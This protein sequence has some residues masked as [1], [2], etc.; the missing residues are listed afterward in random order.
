MHD[1]HYF[2]EGCNTICIDLWRNHEGGGGKYLQSI[3]FG[4]ALGGIIGPVIAKPF[5][6]I[7]QRPEISNLSIPY[8]SPA[9]SQKIDE[10]EVSIFHLFP[11]LG[12]FS[13]L[14]SIGYLVY[15]IMERNECKESINKIDNTIHN[16]CVCNLNKTMQKTSMR[17]TLSLP[18]NRGKQ[19]EKEQTVKRHSIRSWIFLGIMLT[20]FICYVGIEAS[21]SS[22]LSAFS[23]NSKLQLSQQEGTI[24]TSYFWV[25]FATTRLL[26][27]FVP[28]RVSSLQ[29]ICL[30]LSIINFGC[31][32]LCIYSDTSK[33]CLSVFSA[34]VGSALGP[35]FGNFIMWLEKHLL[36]DVNVNA[37][38]TIFGSIGG[39]LIP[40]LVGQ[41]IKE[42]PMFLMYLIIGLSIGLIQLFGA[43]YLVG[44]KIKDIK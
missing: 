10:P 41:L 15:E 22:L 3:H 27:I 4:F 24:I 23:V 42:M 34:V 44:R 19:L 29:G 28:N 20:F 33:T 35:L 30:S 2:I 40:T 12:S 7:R 21:L 31:I 18:K 36:V 8:E 37:L 11:I 13:C 16:D 39:S 26:Y 1:I 14:I 17:S 5:L 32:L 6:S 9:M 25:A 43:S 38:I